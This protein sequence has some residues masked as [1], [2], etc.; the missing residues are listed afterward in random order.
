MDKMKAITCP[1]CGNDDV[2]I[3]YKE[4]IEGGKILGCDMCVKEIDLE[5]LDK[6]RKQAA[7]DMR[8]DESR[9]K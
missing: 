9:G 7:E 3:F 1:I 4:N 6:A 5:E 2:D 8:L